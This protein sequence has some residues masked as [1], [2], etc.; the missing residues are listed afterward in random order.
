MTEA[1][2]IAIDHVKQFHP[3]LSIIVFSKDGRWLYMDENFTPFKFDDKI[4]V[5]I[6]ETASDSIETL[7]FILDITVYE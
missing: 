5:G 6:L 1:L 7:P 3:T 4:D 2:Q